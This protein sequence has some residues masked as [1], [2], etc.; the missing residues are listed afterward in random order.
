MIIQ[1]LFS[2][3]KL[4]LWRVTFL[5]SYLKTLPETVPFYQEVYIHHFVFSLHIICSTDFVS[6]LG[7]RKNKRTSP[8]R[9]CFEGLCSC[10]CTCT[11]ALYMHH[12]ILYVIQSMCHCHCCVFIIRKQKKWKDSAARYVCWGFVFLLVLLLYTC[13]LTCYTDTRLLSLEHSN[14]FIRLQDVS[15]CRSSSVVYKT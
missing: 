15:I 12:D 1:S 11:V 9:T 13:A 5:T 6:S 8:Q 2:P 10:W 7:A 4:V 14:H 3:S